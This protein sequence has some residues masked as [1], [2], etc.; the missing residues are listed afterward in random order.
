MSD[1]SL[2]YKDAVLYELNVRTFFDGNDDG[3]GDFAG[4]TRKLDYLQDLGITALWL[5]PF[6]PS[7]L[8]D[9]GYDIADYF[10]VHPDYGNLADFKTFLREA[11][12]RGLRV[13]TEL[14][15]NHTSDQHELFKRAR[16]AP[17]GSP[18]R[19]FYVWS[20]A[21]T[22]YP[23]ARIIFKDFE[24]SNWTW[25]PVAKAYYWHR[26]YSHQPDLNFDNPETVRYIMKAVD[27]WLGMGV[28]GLRLDAIPYLYEREGTNCE[29]L[30]ET[31]AFLKELR[32]HVDAKFKDRMLLAEANQWPE[33]A[34]AYFGS[35][36]ECHMAFH[37][38][39]MPRLFTALH[40]ED[41]FPIVD[42]LKQTPAIPDAQ[43][44]AIFLRNH[45]ELTLEM[46]TDEERDY[47]YR[48]YAMDPRS[49]IN[50]GI[51]RRLAPLLG[52][53]RRKI[54]LLNGLLFSLPGSPVL[55]YGDEIGMGDN[56]YL[57]DRNGV[58]T[59]MQWS[60]DRNAGFSGANSQ[61]LCL[62]IIID[63]EYNYE[64]VNVDV[65]QNN[66]HSLLWW[67]K[68]I[69]D[70][71]KRYEAFG[72]GSLEPVGCENRRVLAFVRS[73]G[74]ERIL[75]VANLSRYVQFAELDLSASK[76]MALVEMFGRIEFPP[77]E[78]K[79]Y[80]LTLGPHSFYWFRLRQ[81]TVPGAQATML[82]AEP[83]VIE[84]PEGCERILSGN[85]RVRLREVLVPYLQ[86]R[87]WFEGRTRSVRS[88]RILD[89]IV[90]RYGDGRRAHI[91]LLQVE[92]LDMSPEAY[93]LPVGIASGEH[94]DQ[95]R[96]ENPHAVI[97]EI[98]RKGGVE[99]LFDATTE[100]AFCSELLSSIRKGS[101]LKGRSGDAFLAATTGLS[102]ETLQPTLAKT[103]QRNTS[104]MFGE[105]L[106][107]KLFRK[108]ESGE[109]PDVEI[110][111]FLSEKKDFRHSPSLAGGIQY[112]RRKGE[113][114][115][116]AVLHGYVPNRGT[117][118]QYTLDEVRRYFDE[119]LAAPASAR[120]KF[121]LVS[122]P[123][124]LIDKDPDPL[125]VEHIGAYLETARL[126]GKRT[127]ELHFA[128]SSEPGDPAFAPEEFSELYQR[129][130]CQSMR[131]RAIDG[132][133][134]LRKRVNDMPEHRRAEARS[135]LDKEAEVLKR[136][137]SL[138]GKKLSGLR[139]RCHGD[140]H[141]K[142]VLY[143][144]VDF[145]IFGFEGPTDRTF[146][147]R[148]AKRSPLRDVAGMLRSFH[149]AAYT[150]LLGRV[151][152]SR[153]EDEAGLDGAARFW[154][155]WVASAFLRA[156]LKTAQTGAFLPKTSKETDLLLSTL[157]LERAIE[158]LQTELNTHPEWTILPLKG[159]SQ[160]LEVR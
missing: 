31:H 82:P 5:L 96:R 14:V 64:A 37:F 97:S 91:L 99:L 36:D 3:V 90:L 81:P 51:R 117:A 22:R 107:L 72:S 116:L 15:L 52:S 125:A 16:R 79:P 124:A 1:H 137:R 78:D 110:S 101:R 83:R 18:E 121:S 104:V 146:Q 139:I 155:Q 53:H 62:P 150:I 21:P 32:R 34:A 76:G 93:L 26:F 2:W 128:L 95:V 57:G 126:L 120:E 69:I 40:M 103:E 60:S 159:L 35:G 109:N 73:H 71:R 28:D 160:L 153:A 130:L 119:L 133:Y 33:D 122:D 100:P 94:S 75:V 138:V 23:D 148:R 140:Y 58:R 20:D 39:I 92:Y 84:A 87:T 8:R 113:A 38:P 114:V 102:A 67:M 88:L 152:V 25:D 135:A 145:Q 47:M 6:Y 111:R 131:N 12:R 134:L 143:T 19:A 105:R 118:W 156:Y 149:Y 10:N 7:P 85:D 11:K 89:D 70:L 44:W 151:G 54:E 13:V 50:L 30:P 141:L 27:F 106:I 56:I 29:N 42:I 147:E 74:S 43:Q 49:R 127:A 154:Y 55:Y 115:D 45:D 68:R 9:D 41:C 129:S 157:L 80:V 63:P 46:V 158:E 142:Q 123:L 59:P 112:R 144:G 66:P 24:T 77:I 48:V 17:A 136:F 98:R 108:L 4:L 61:K 132:F 86:A 65:Q